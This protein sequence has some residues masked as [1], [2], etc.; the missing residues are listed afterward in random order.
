MTV[1]VFRPGKLETTD[2]IILEI[3]PRFF[4]KPLHCA[5]L[6][7]INTQKKKKTPIS[8]LTLLYFT[9]PNLPKS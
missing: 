6:F 1:C 7:K 5:E 9:D 2:L 3:I 8:F 4:K